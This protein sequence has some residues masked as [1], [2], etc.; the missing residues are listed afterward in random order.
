M[1]LNEL[2]INGGF[3]APEAAANQHRD[4]ATIISM[5]RL[6]KKTAIRDIFGSLRSK[7]QIGREPDSTSN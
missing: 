5:G 1:S 6:G 4:I 3:A 7:G 2:C